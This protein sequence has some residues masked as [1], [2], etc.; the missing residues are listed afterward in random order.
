MRVEGKSCNATIIK[1]GEFFDILVSF[2]GNIKPKTIVKYR[3]P[4]PYDK[5]QSISGSG[6]PFPNPETAYSG[7]NPNT[8][9]IKVDGNQIRLRLLR[10]NTYYINAGTTLVPP[11]LYIQIGKYEDLLMI[12]Y[13]LPHK[14]LTFPKE[15]TGPEFYFKPNLPARNQYVIL[16]ENTSKNDMVYFTET[17]KYWNTRPRH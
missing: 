7:N 13:M 17:L 9:M 5:R 16:E 14:S 12:P 4:A 10:P 8:G 1:D 15:R 6:M 3:A 11:H 2:K